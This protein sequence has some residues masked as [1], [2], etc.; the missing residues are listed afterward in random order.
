MLQQ[1]IGGLAAGSSYALIAL[2]IV[3]IMKSTDVPNFAMAEMGLVVA[4]VAWG[5]TQAGLPFLV[6]VGLSLVIA[7]GFGA[8]VEFVAL[9]PLSGASHFPTLLMTIGLTFAFGALI[10]LWGGS[11]PVNFSSP[12][13][14][15]TYSVGGQVVSLSALVTIGTGIVVALLLSAFFKT[16]WGV[17]MRAIAENRSVSRLLG[18][19]TGRVSALAW[20]MGTVMAGL[21]LILATSSSVLSPTIGG[22]LILKGFVAAVLGGFTSMIG[23]FLGGLL[24]GVLENM[25]GAYIST[26]SKSAI[27][28]VVVF[29][30]L[31]WKP[32]GM[33]SAAR[34][35]E[36]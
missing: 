33:F 6:A 4:Y 32:E 34:A 30:V 21:A 23:A 27:A 24:I 20:A 35:R 29:A 11:A 10:H 12:W 15:T 22:A 31:L 19:S 17:Q 1:L 36:V 25:A 9:R 28:L 26:S 3:V 5:F 16:G 18:I 13:A 2:A 8:L 7:A 14:T